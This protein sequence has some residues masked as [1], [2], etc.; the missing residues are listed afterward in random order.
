MNI[1]R[2]INTYDFDVAIIGGGLGRA[3]TFNFISQKKL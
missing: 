3:F 1:D 2:E